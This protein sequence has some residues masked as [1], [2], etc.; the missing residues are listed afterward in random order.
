MPACGTAGDDRTG[1]V[2]DRKPGDM[3]NVRSRGTGQGSA[4]SVAWA[5]AVS[6]ADVGSL[7]STTRWK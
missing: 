6:V 3:L 2:A 1:D 7:A 4:F 5:C